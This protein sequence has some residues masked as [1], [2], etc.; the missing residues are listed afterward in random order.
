MFG[1]SRVLR[2]GRGHVRLCGLPRCTHPLALLQE[3]Q[4]LRACDAWYDLMRLRLKKYI[5]D[6]PY[7]SE[8]LYFGKN[9]YRISSQIYAYM[10]IEIYIYTENNTY[11]Y[12]LIT[13][14]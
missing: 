6:A 8:R 3:G 1:N 11:I 13:V 9:V 7:V 10:Y 2:A 12:I 4:T 5:H 14:V